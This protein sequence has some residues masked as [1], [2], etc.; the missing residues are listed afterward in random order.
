[1]S[2][3]VYDGHTLPY[4][5]DSFDVT[6]AICVMHHVPPDNWAGF[7]GE[8]KRVTAPG[9]L[10]IIFEHNPLNPLTR[11]VVSR[12]EFDKDAVLLW[13]KALKEAFRRNSLAIAERSYL[14]FF[15]FASSFAARI[16]KMIRWLPLGAQY[17]MGAVKS[18]AGRDQQSNKS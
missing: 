10:C 2:Y 13:P 14:L 18:T 15:P 7:L 6:F 9:G 3:S 5:D 8:M 11:A 1:M 16:E 17:Y 12:C 4:P